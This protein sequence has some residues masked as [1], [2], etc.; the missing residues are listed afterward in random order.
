MF[1]MKIQTYFSPLFSGIFNQYNL[2]VSNIFN[3]FFLSI[4]VPM[5]FLCK[6]VRPFSI[7]AFYFVPRSDSKEIVNRNEVI[8]EM[9][10]RLSATRPM[11]S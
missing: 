6:R 11:R 8:Q 10:K 9:G 4:D 3:F 7:E 5:V 2:L 1:Q